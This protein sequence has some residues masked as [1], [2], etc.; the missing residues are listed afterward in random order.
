MNVRAL[1]AL[2]LLATILYGSRPIRR[3]EPIRADPPRP[4]LACQGID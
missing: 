4:C 3:V 2:V 1:A